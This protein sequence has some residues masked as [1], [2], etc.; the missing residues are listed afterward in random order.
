M[1]A[2]ARE[3]VEGPSRLP[4][5]DAKVLD[6][7]VPL[8]CRATSEPMIFQGVA[9][10]WGP[11]PRVE[12]VS[13]TKKGNIVVH[14]DSHARLHWELRTQHSFPCEAAFPEECGAAYDRKVAL[15][16]AMAEATSQAMQQ[17]ALEAAQGGR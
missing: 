17:A 11:P 5:I 3:A 13:G 15:E 14:P 12:S 9:M 16:Q 8:V 1:V 7:R 2:P 6:V 10:Q 4:H